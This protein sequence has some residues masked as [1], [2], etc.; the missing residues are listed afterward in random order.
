MPLFRLMP[1]VLALA[2]LA[3]PLHAIFLPPDL[4]KIPI[5]R[6]AK[7]LQDAIDNNPKDAQLVLNLARAHAMAYSIKS[8]TVE[9]NKKKPNEAWFG[10]EPSIVPFSTVKKTDDAEKQKA[11]KVHLEKALEL[12]EKAVKLAPDNM[13][14]RLGQAWLTDQSGKKDDA[15]KLY[16][17]L[18]EEGWAKEKDLK[19]L[20]FGGH[21]I[22]GETAGYLIPLLDKDKDKDEIATLKER[23]EQLRKLPRPIT[24]IA[25][26]LR[27][28]LSARDLEDRT[29]SVAFDADGTGLQKK[30]TWITKDAAWLV[31]DPKNSGQVTSALQLFGN[32]TF[33]MFWDTGYDA[34]AALDD[35]RDGRLSG[36]ELNGLSLWHDANGNGISDRGEVK[37]LAEYGIAAL[38]CKFERDSTHPAR[39]AFSK[40]GVTFKDGK[41][42]P[43]FDLVLHQAR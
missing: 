18:V 22:T 40:L 38:S 35:N 17:K 39:I 37:P 36:K 12:Y 13:Q 7:N 24:P 6:L 1:I 41:T 11:A 28:G 4:E 8:D 32:V 16:R 33:W 25:V 26:P 9:I 23:A 30:W 21:T 15:V 42:R 27:D 14:A 3:A 31:Y 19:A 5:E 10:F 2:L 29:A 20:G 43:T 34:L